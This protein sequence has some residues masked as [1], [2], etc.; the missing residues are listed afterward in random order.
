MCIDAPVSTTNSLPSGL[1][2]D[3]AGRHKFSEGEKNALFTFSFNFW[4]S[5]T[6]L[7]G[8][9]ALAIPSLLETDPQM[10]EH[11]GYADEDHLGKSFQAMDSGLEC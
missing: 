7:H 11:W 5:S 4:P 1:R 2:V 9:L 3:G 6:L 8:H 10:L